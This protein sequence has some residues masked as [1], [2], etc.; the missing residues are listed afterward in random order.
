MMAIGGR[1]YFRGAPKTEYYFREV[2]SC[3]LE[4]CLEGKKLSF[5]S[6]RG[7]VVGGDRKKVGILAPLDVI[8]GEGTKNG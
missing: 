6:H 8:T 4:G 1:G 2:R 3:R 7:G 5:W